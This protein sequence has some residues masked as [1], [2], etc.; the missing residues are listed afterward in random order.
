MSKCLLI[1]FLLLISLC[2]ESQELDPTKPLG[3]TV[4]TRVSNK[5]TKIKG[6]D[7]VLQSIIKINKTK[8]AVVDG[9]ILNIGDKYNGF[10]LKKINSKSVVFNSSQSQKEL[11]L[12]SS[13][14]VN[15]K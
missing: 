12:F 15:S 6:D 9:K 11:F 8:K 4:S 2:V 14:I 10:E 1:S 3:I 7:W 13:I 5:N